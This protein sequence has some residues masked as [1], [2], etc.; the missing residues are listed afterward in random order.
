MQLDFNLAKVKCLTSYENKWHP[1]CTVSYSI[2]LVLV[3]FLMCQTFI[4]TVTH[5]FTVEVIRE[6]LE[7]LAAA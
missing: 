4:F 5:H 1:L 6:K 3:H 2:H 7:V